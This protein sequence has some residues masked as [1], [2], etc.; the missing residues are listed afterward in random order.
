MT[1]LGTLKEV[2]SEHTSS[3]I[4]VAYPIDEHI[5]DTELFFVVIIQHLA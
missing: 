2:T 1:K 4:Q 3:A 5:D